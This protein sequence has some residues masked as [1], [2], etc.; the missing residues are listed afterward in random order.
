MKNTELNNI[1]SKIYL[2]RGHKVM[3]DADLANLYG[4]ATSNLKRA[5]RRNAERFPVDFMFQL[6]NQE[7]R[8]LICQFGILKDAIRAGERF[9]PFVFTQEGVAML[10]SV[11]NS[12]RAIEVNITIMRAFVKIRELLANHKDLSAKLTEL[13]KKYDGQFKLVFD[14]IRELMSSHAVPRKRVIGFGGRS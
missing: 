13:E 9:A 6:T 14:A 11:L 4:V 1:E 5:V 12:K 7:V 3:L 2:I 8:G 10:S